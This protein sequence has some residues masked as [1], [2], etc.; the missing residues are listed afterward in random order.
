MNREGEGGEPSQKLRRRERKVTF[1][2]MERVKDTVARKQLKIRL[3][4][5]LQ[6]G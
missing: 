4:R 3:K 2:L 6:F 1:V 5:Q